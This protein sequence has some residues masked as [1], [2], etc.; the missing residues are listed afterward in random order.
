[1]KEKINCL[2]AWM[3]ANGLPAEKGSFLI[4]SPKYRYKRGGKGGKK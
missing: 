1:M 3:R 2:K 4:E